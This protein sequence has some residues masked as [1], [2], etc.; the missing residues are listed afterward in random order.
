M[1]NERW[2]YLLYVIQKRDDSCSNN[3]NTCKYT[4]QKAPVLKDKDSPKPSPGIEPGFLAWQFFYC[5]S[6]Q[7]SPIL[8]LEFIKNLIFFF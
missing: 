1:R 8:A 3:V 6:H 5:L 4:S 2:D 7:E